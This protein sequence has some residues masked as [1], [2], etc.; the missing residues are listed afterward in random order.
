MYCEKKHFYSPLITSL[1]GAKVSPPRTIYIYMEN[2]ES[3]KAFC[4]FA[5]FILFSSHPNHCLTMLFSDLSPSFTDIWCHRFLTLYS[6]FLARKSS[7][8]F[9][10]KQNILN[11]S[12][13][14]LLVCRRQSKF[15]FLVSLGE[16]VNNLY[17]FR[18]YS[19][20]FIY[21]FT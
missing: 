21:L 1:N 20:D 17:L 18:K 14:L 16:N 3:S 5:S 7:S 4:Q 9:K 13:R 10:N 2:I 6:S 8:N 12:L 11:N 15:S 19:L